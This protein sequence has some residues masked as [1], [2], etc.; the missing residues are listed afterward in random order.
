MITTSGDGQNRLSSDAEQLAESIQDVIL[1]VLRHIQPMVEAEG[2]S[3]PQFLTMHVLSSLEPASVSTVARHLAV[4]APTACVTVDQLEAA[5]LVKR[6][7]SERDHRTVE[8]S[9]TPKGRRVEARVW[10]QI[11]QRVAHAARG[12]PHEDVAATVRVVRELNHRL[13]PIAVSRGV[14]A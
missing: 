1:S 14:K 6:Q 12:L 13:Q 5:G 9:L 10:S 7:R 3:K 4:K 8:L 11:G 2:I